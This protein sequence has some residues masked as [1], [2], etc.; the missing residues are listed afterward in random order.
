MQETSGQPE[1]GP[2]IAFTAEATSTHLYVCRLIQQVIPE[3]LLGAALGDPYKGATIWDTRPK[4]IKAGLIH[5]EEPLASLPFKP[6]TAT[7]PCVP[8]N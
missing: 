4:P 3:H 7:E 1:G 2:Q 5:C 8:S 6:D